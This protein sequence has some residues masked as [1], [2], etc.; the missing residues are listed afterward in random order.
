MILLPLAS[1][2]TNHRPFFPHNFFG[3]F[4]HTVSCHKKKTASRPTSRPT[5]LVS[6]HRP[7]AAAGRD[8]LR[9]QLGSLGARGAWRENGGLPKR[10]G[11]WKSGAVVHWRRENHCFDQPKGSKCVKP[12][13]LSTSFYMFLPKNLEKVPKEPEGSFEG[14]MSQVAVAKHMVKKW[15]R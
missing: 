9:R 15:W 8:A 4:F 13:E 6:H 3:T 14:L 7:P 5:T 10:G 2:L 12:Y 11:R 1:P